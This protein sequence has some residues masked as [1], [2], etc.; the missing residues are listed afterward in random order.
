[1]RRRESGEGAWTRKKRAAKH[2]RGGT[3]ESEQEMR[4]WCTREPNINETPGQS[5]V[6]GRTPQAA[7]TQQHGSK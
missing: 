7:R 6:G 1:M 2:N 3:G 4:A 5:K